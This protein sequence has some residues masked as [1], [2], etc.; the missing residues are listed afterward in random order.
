[1]KVGGIFRLWD[2]EECARA[3]QLLKAAIAAGNGRQR[4]CILVGKALGRSLNGVSNRLTNYGPTFN[5]ASFHAHRMPHKRKRVW[6]AE[7]NSV[8]NGA[9]IAPTSHLAVPQ[10]VIAERD[11][12]QALEHPTITAAFFGDPKPGYSAL[13]RA[14]R[15]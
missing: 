1:M 7:R 3:A 12:R 4:A 13:D 11:Y 8:P 6:S 2:K 10:A 5:D 9:S 14:R 15:A